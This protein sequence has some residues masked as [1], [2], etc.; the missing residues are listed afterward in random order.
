MSSLLYAGISIR[1]G[2]LGRRSDQLLCP[3]SLEKEHVGEPCSLVSSPRLYLEGLEWPKEPSGSLLN[4]LYAEVLSRS[5]LKPP[6]VSLLALF[7]LIMQI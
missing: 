6:L 2:A 5:H 4:L 3:S 7:F 1:A